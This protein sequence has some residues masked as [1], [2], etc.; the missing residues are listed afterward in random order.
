MNLKTFQ[1]WKKAMEKMKTHA[2]STIHIQSCEAEV[3]AAGKSTIVQQLLQIG[4]Q[5]KLKNRMAILKPLFMCT[6]FLTHHHTTSFD[7]LVDLI[8]GYGVEDLKKFLERAGKNATYASK[9]KK[10]NCC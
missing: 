9:K 2:K 5:E 10:A 1:N 7:K 6:H 3:P 4:D 8:M